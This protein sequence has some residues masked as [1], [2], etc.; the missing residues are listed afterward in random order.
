M[1]FS[2]YKDKFSENIFSIPIYEA[3]LELIDNGDE[4]Y[5]YLKKHY[6]KYS[7]K[8]VQRKYH[9]DKINLI[10]H[11]CYPSYSFI[12][13]KT[14]NVMEDGVNANYNIHYNYLEFILFNLYSPHNDEDI[15]SVFL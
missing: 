12:I 13:N 15:V 6:H 10:S 8:N 11:T 5:L 4:N 7:F 14:N 9:N 2:Y 3:L 1:D